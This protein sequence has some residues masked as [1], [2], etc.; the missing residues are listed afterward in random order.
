MVEPPWEKKKPLLRQLARQKLGN[1]RF[2]GVKSESTILWPAA[3]SFLPTVFS[4]SRLLAA[5]SL[6][7]IFVASVQTLCST[8]T[9]HSN[10]VFCPPPPPF[11][12]SQRSLLCTH[13]NLWRQEP[14]ALSFSRTSFFF[15]FFF[16]GTPP[17]SSLSRVVVHNRQT[18][19][20]T[21]PCNPCSARQPFLPLEPPTKRF[22]RSIPSRLSFPLATS[23]RGECC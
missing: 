14:R 11:F 2:T 15:I 17:P 4:P 7:H 19:G 3:S 13:S 16:K 6:V 10:I 5:N 9:L 18:D 12:R 23:T 20:A 8:N 1:G 21:G 22:E